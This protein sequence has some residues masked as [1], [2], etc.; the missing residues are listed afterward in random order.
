[1]ALKTRVEKSNYGDKS[2]PL[3]SEEYAKRWRLEFSSYLKRKDEHPKLIDSYYHLGQK[4]RLWTFLT[5]ANGEAFRTF[6]DFCKAPEPYGLGAEPTNIVAVLELV[7]GKRAAQLETVAEAAAPKAG[8]G[9][10]HKQESV[11][12]KTVRHDGGLFSERSTERLRAINRAPD[13][14]REAYKD[15]RIS[16]GLAAKLGPK[17]PTPEQAATAAEIASVVRKTKD[18]KEVDKLVRQRLG[19]HQ[20]TAVDRAIGILR[21]M[22]AE[23]LYE[24]EEQFN[25]LLAKRDARVQ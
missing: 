2:A 16:Q 3:C 8:P 13:A 7:H 10:G 22:S 24:F 14:I 25:A 4:H 9:R 12:D 19:A 5:N 15:G 18:R 6:D 1:V 11:D 17:N 20:S 23:E 21:R